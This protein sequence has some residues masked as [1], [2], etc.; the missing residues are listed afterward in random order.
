[1]VIRSKPDGYTLF[2]VNSGNVAVTP[3]VVKDANY[4]GV[5]DF[6]PVALVSA[7]PLFVVVPA[8]LPVE[9][10]RGFIAYAKTHPIAYASAGIGSFGQLAS[11]LFASK[12]G[13]KMT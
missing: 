8:A 9:D 11:E 1:E 6:S 5:K 12:A 4:D 3:Q 10:L 13:I 2:F 7:A